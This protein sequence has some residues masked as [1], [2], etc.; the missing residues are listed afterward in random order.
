MAVNT[1]PSH[2]LSAEAWEGELEFRRE[3]RRRVRQYCD[4]GQPW[5]V[6]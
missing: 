3:E 5:E 6:S 2:L 1:Q 4:G